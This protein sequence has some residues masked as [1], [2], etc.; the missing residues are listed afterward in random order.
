MLKIDMSQSEELKK[1]LIDFFAGQTEQFFQCSKK[2]EKNAFLIRFAVGGCIIY[3][4]E[5][6]NIDPNMRLVSFDV[7]FRRNDTQWLIDLP[8]HL[9]QKVMM[10]SCCGHFFCF[11]SHQDYLLKDGVDAQQFKDEVLAYLEQRGAKYPAEH[12]VGHIYHASSGY[13][14]HLKKLD[15]TNTFNPGIGKTSKSKHWQ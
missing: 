14:A 7:A 4:C 9:K 8:E 12:N 10:E 1:L 6:K 5:S 13:E 2:E 11:V 3:Y 15:P